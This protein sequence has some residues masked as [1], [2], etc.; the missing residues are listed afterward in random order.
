MLTLTQPQLPIELSNL[1]HPVSK[2]YIEGSDFEAL[3][4]RPRLAIVGS[5]KITPYGRE[6]TESLT[7]SLAEKGVV[8]ISGLAIGT[9]SVAH[10]ACLD[11]G[12]HTIAVLPA[13]LEKIYPKQHSSLAEDIIKQGGALVTEYGPSTIPY[14]S[15]FLERN[16]IIAALSEGVLVTEAAVRSGSLNT[17]SHAL[18]IGKPV[19]AVPGNINNPLAAGCNNL[20]KAGAIPVTC[21]QDVLDELGWVQTKANRLPL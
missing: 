10:K 21:I 5:R 17:A 14:P 11:A 7:A 9:D 12:G 13:G 2:L 20:I 18:S 8:I 15:N 16:R 1:P 19:F 4:S 6:V 3:M